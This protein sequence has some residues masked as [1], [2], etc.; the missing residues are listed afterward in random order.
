MNTDPK[1]SQYFFTRR[2]DREKLRERL[3]RLEQERR[4]LSLSMVERIQT[5]H[6]R[7]LILLNRHAQLTG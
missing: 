2:P 6:D 5:L 7:L 1:P 3:A 4:R